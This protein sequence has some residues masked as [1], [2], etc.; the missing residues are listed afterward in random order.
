M[1]DRIDFDLEILQSSI[2]A[3]S[4]RQKRFKN[5]DERL[6]TH[7]PKKDSKS[8]DDIDLSDIKII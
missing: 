2:L 7:K 4:T 3:P 6:L 1:D 5:R 8:M